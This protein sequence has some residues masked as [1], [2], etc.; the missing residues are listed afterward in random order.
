MSFPS[1]PL[2]RVVMRISYITRLNEN[3]D[4]EV[5]SGQPNHISDYANGGIISDQKIRLKGTGVSLEARLI[6]FKIL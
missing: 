4:Y 2:Q 5:L 6:I 3:A 1:Q